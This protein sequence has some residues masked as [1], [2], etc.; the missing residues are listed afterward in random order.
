[1]LEISSIALQE[2][3]RIKS[4]SKMSDSLVRLEVKPGGCSGFFYNF[5]L[6]DIEAKDKITDSSTPSQDQLIKIGNLELAVDLQS[7]KY[8]ENLKIDY[9]EDLMGGGFR[10]HNRDAKN[11]CGCGISFAQIDPDVK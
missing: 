5:K 2:I 7:W 1:M 4:N 3:K 8:I 10:F 11:V 6:E 9:S